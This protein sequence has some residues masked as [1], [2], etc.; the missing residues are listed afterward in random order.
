MAGEVLGDGRGADVLDPE[1]VAKR[2]CVEL[3][4]AL[5]GG[6]NQLASRGEQ[7]GGGAN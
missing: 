7:G 1:I 5:V 6:K 3:K 2:R 4:T